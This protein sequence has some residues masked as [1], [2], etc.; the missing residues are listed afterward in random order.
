MSDERHNDVA[1]RDERIRNSI[2]ATGDVSADATFRERLKRE[3]AA[4]TISEP[5]VQ[6]EQRE[7][8]RLPRWTWLL[9]PAAAVILVVALILPKP[10]PTWTIY[11]TGS[12]VI[13]GQ[14]LSTGDADTIARALVSGGDVQVPDGSSLHLRLDDRLI[15]ALIEGTDATVPAPPQPD[16]EGLLISEVRDGELRL[17]TGP[18][19]PGSRLHVLTTEGRTEISGTI[20]SVYKG[21]GYTCVCVLEGTALIGV[22]ESSL[23]EIPP[24]MLKIMFD[25]G[26]PPFVMD[27]STE[28]KEGL[29]DFSEQYRGAFE[30]PE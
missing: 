1:G 25:D 11:G 7:A 18:G 10:D 8:P 26:S 5:A 29:L 21:D 27:I 28:H 22:D 12:V 3:F 14:T 24:G 4:G 6:P 23:D 20:V 17:K 30:A 19:F 13:N 9:V 15:L 16:S 2:R